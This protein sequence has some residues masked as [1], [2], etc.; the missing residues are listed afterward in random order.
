MYISKKN[1]LYYQLKD[2]AKQIAQQ[3]RFLQANTPL[4]KPK[5]NDKRYEANK[6][7]KDS[8]PRQRQQNYFAL[9]S[10]GLRPTR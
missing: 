7:R 4:Y 5:T 2:M 9:T 6:Y 10:D 8:K 3:N 1:K